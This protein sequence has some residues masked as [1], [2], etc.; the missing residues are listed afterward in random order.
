MLSRESVDSLADCANQPGSVLDCSTPVEEDQL[1]STKRSMWKQ[2]LGAAAFVGAVATSL[3]TACASGGGDTTGGSEGTATGTKTVD[4]AVL[5]TSNMAAVYLGVKEGFFEDEGLDLNLTTVG[6]GA[7]MIAGIQAGSFDFIAVGYV[8]LFA[9]AASGLPVRMIAANDVGGATEEEE[10]Q[11]VVVGADSD[12][13]SAADLEGATIGVN[14]LK[15]V[16]EA[17]IRASMQKQGLDDSTVQFVEV[18]FAE[19]PPAV[20]NGTVDA[21]LTAEPFITQTLAD[22][23]RIV[24]TPSL[25]L[26]KHFPNGVWATSQELV[27]A[28]PELV[29]AF[30]RAITKS[31]EFASENPDA[32]REILPTFTAL[33]PELAAAIR[34]PV[35]S[36]DLDRSQLDTFI[37]ILL[38]YEVIESAPD[39]DQMIRD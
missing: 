7:D 29:D 26:G 8:P 17:T 15:G 12:I 14:A 10:W 4:V 18:P 20:A 2:R 21:G 24:E 9:A 5:P 11:A 27:D 35:F 13:Q 3:L 39:L 22:G 6:G 38:T 30:T 28:D 32:V 25:K 33:S 37:E 23:G 34:L 19:V 1:K 31:V 16:A 36:A